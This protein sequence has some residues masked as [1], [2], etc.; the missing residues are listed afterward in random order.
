MKFLE[1]FGMT[2]CKSMATLMETNF[3]K[4]CGKAVGLDLANPSEYRQLIGVVMFLVNTSPDICYAVNTLIQFMT[5]PLHAHWISSKHVLSYLDGSITL[6]LRYS[7]G[8][9]QLH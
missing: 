7:I 3:K 6:G 9:I 4:L 1:S 8:D 5:E 2:E